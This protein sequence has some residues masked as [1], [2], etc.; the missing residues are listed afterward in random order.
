MYYYVKISL[1]PIL[2]AESILM[3]PHSA[4]LILLYGR[5]VIFKAFTFHLKL[6]VLL[7]FNYTTH[8]EPK[9]WLKDDSLT[10]LFQ[11]ILRPIFQS[12][13]INLYQPQVPFAATH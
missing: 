13:P 3:I 12:F 9:Q 10:L 8:S 11:N 5:N 4:R 6:L 7:Y 1:Y 2:W